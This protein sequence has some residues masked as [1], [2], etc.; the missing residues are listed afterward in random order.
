[1]ALCKGD[2]KHSQKSTPIIYT[3]EIPMK[4]SGFLEDFLL[5]F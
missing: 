4:F 2:K 3:I 1:M 5:Y